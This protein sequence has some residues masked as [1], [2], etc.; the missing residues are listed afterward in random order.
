MADPIINPVSPLDNGQVKS[1]HGEYLF[2]FDDTDTSISLSDC[3]ITGF[4]SKA[5]R[6]DITEVGQILRANFNDT[7]PNPVLSSS[8]DLSLTSN[9][10]LAVALADSDFNNGMFVKTS[11]ASDGGCAVEA[12]LDFPTFS[13]VSDGPY[14]AREYYTSTDFSGVSLGVFD[15]KTGKALVLFFNDND[16]V[17]LSGPSQDGVGTRTTVEATYAWSTQPSSQIFTIFMDYKQDRVVVTVNQSESDADTVLFDTTISTFG[18][19]LE[20]TSLAFAQKSTSDDLIFFV[21]QDGREIG[22]TVIIED[23]AVHPE[24]YPYLFRGVFTKYVSSGTLRTRDSHTT[25]ID[26]SKW[27]EANNVTYSTITNFAKL[28]FISASGYL[29]NE[30]ADLNENT[31]VLSCNASTFENEFNFVSTGIGIDI[32]GTRLFKIRFLEDGIGVQL[33][34]DPLV[35]RTLAGFSYYADVDQEK[36]NHYIFSSD[37]TTFKVLL[38]GDR[39]ILS[40]IISVAVSSLPANS[41][42][43]DYGIYFASDAQ[44]T[45]NLYLKDFSFCPTAEVALSS[46]SSENNLSPLTPPSGP[47]TYTITTVTNYTY[48][49]TPTSISGG[50]VSIPN[51][52]PKESGLTCILKASINEA[53]P[54]TP[55]TEYGPFLVLNSGTPNLSSESEYAI[56]LFLVKSPNGKKYFYFPS[57]AQDHREVAYQSNKGRSISFEAPGEN[58]LHS[59]FYC[60]RF[61][62]KV[63]FFVYDVLDNMNIVFQ[64]AWNAIEGIERL[65][66][67]PNDE[68][69]I[70]PIDM[71]SDSH[72][73]GAVG[74]MG[75]STPIRNIVSFCSF[76]IG[77]GFDVTLFKNSDIIDPSS[78]YGSRSRILVSIEDND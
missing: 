61:V 5:D 29:Y 9:I 44:S 27:W 8:V 71:A 42:A 75:L 69:N 45:G 4:Y 73:T 14:T 77:R 18:T 10:E 74:S 38:M 54:I 68:G 32:V 1:F 56:Q 64:T 17:V 62:P 66:P 30:Y 34:D 35:L 20:T 78:F 37:G 76:G 22:D 33:S 40:E 57:D 3:F 51:Y 21:A 19:C 31:F 25:D 6:S 15:F 70:L 47:T 59:F 55:V 7:G 43:I 2:T 52:L 41:S 11:P 23:Y 26:F 53:S 24:A 49:S 63:G 39:N 72:F 36:P 50:Y 67:A 60:F 28:A 13:F 12:R 58:L 16:K 46:P 48:T 65:L